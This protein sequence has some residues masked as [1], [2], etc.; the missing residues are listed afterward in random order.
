[1]KNILAENMRRFGT[2]NLSEGWGDVLTLAKYTSEFKTIL[3]PGQ[4][5]YTITRTIESMIQDM[6]GA[7][8]A[9]DLMKGAMESVDRVKT[10]V[11]PFIFKGAGLDVMVLDKIVKGLP[12]DESTKKQLK[13]NI[14]QLARDLNVRIYDDQP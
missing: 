14:I 11:K 1:M 10:F 9:A 8:E 5:Q 7:A 2:K 6:G 3:E 13:Y 4:S 12:F